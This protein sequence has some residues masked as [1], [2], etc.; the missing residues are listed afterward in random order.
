MKRYLGTGLEEKKIH[1][2]GIPGSVGPFLLPT[3]TRQSTLQAVLWQKP[4]IV[5]VCDS[6]VTVTVT[7]DIYFVLVWFRWLRIPQSSAIK[8]RSVSCQRSSTPSL[9]YFFILYFPRSSLLHVF[10]YPLATVSM[11]R[12][13]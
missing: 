4:R 3:Q 12:S 10:K 2:S 1:L 13:S 6:A 8:T 7:L 9:F 11:V 5:H